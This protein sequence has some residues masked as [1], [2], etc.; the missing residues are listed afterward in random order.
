MQITL[1]NDSLVITA[2][3]SRK[4]LV[5]NLK[6]KTEILHQIQRTVANDEDVEI[7]PEAEAF[8]DNIIEGNRLLY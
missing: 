8:I 5:S 6:Y 2:K 3:V 4:D 7:S 1:E